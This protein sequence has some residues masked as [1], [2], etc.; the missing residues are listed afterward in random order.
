[1]IHS[2]QRDPVPNAERR[3]QGIDLIANE[4][5]P[6]EMAAVRSLGWELAR[7]RS[8][9]KLLAARL[10]NGTLSGSITDFLSRAPL[11]AEMPDVGDPVTLNLLLRQNIRGM[12][13]LVPWDALGDRQA[14]ARIVA[15]LRLPALRGFWE[16]TLRRGH[17]QRLLRVLP[18]AWFLEADPPPPG[19]VVPDLGLVSRSRPPSDARVELLAPEKPSDAGPLLLIETICADPALQRLAATYESKAGRVTLAS[20]SL[21]T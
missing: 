14:A 15:L 2:F 9:L 6:G 7:L 16:R 17:F 10:R 13:L 5:A 11:L 8:G 20:A 3:L 18:H 21:A 19:A 12:K 4:L 1:M